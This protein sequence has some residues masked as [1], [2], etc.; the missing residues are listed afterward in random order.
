[1]LITTKSVK[2]SVCFHWSCL[3][4]VWCYLLDKREDQRGST[5]RTLTVFFCWGT[6]LQKSKVL[7]SIVLPRIFSGLR[8]ICA[9]CWL[10]KQVDFSILSIAHLHFMSGIGD[11]KFPTL[12]DLWFSYC[13]V[14][15]AIYPDQEIRI[16][17]FFSHVLQG[18]TKGPEK[19]FNI[20]SKCWGAEP[21]RSWVGGW[22]CGPSPM[23]TVYT[24]RW[25]Y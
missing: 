15:G 16:G 6:Y 11:V 25:S 12:S 7:L 3:S 14:W 8:R 2:C 24:T 20:S 18:R 23:W 5:P 9:I 19:V 13:K 17:W 4:P 21:S 1:M 22:I 10:L